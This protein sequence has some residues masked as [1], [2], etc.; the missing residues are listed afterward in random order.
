MAMIIGGNLSRV[1]ARFHG[2]ACLVQSTATSGF[3]SSCATYVSEGMWGKIPVIYQYKS[4]R[5][6]YEKY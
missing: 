6:H 4:W 1:I 2:F 3:Y 5:T